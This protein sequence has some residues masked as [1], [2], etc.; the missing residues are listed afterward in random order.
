MITITRKS[1]LSYRRDP[2]PRKKRNYDS[3]SLAPLF[4]PEIALF[5]RRRAFIPAAVR[6]SARSYPAARRSYRCNLLCNVII[7]L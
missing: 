2:G 3:I 1:S 7:R 4:L 6:A 5:I